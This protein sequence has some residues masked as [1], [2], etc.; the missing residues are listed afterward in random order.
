[1]DFIKYSREDILSYRDQYNLAEPNC[2]KDSKFVILYNK[3]Q[4]NIQY[5]PTGVPRSSFIQKKP[6]DRFDRSRTKFGPGHGPGPVAVLE[7]VILKRGENAW[8]PPSFD[9]KPDSIENPDL[10]RKKEHMKKIRSLLNR[11]NKENLDIMIEQTLIL[12]YRE[13]EI[14]DILFNKAMV[15]PLYSKEYAEYCFKLVDLHEIIRS[16]CSEQFRVKK[17]KNLCRFIGHLYSFNVI[18]NLE[19]F[20]DILIEDLHSDDKKDVAE[21]SLDILCE[22]IKTIGTKKEEFIDIIEYLKNI[23]KSFGRIRC[24]VLIDQLVKSK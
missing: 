12:D 10:L 11:L 24:E 9:K 8:K 15:D 7:P 22:L 18:S 13:P 5:S 19:D 1:M 2:Y 21:K 20:T 4:P 17:H 3:Q 23:N 14:V 6:F 16:M